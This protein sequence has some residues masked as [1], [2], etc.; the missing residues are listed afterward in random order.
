MQ[1]AIECDEH[2]A[3]RVGVHVD[4]VSQRFSG[5]TDQEIVDKA[6]VGGVAFAQAATSKGLEISQNLS[7]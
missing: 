6:R 4:D 1:Q 5:F 7:S 3:E 2:Q